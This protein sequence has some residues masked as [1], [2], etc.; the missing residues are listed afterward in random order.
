MI[1]TFEMWFA[2]CACGSEVR[3]AS[4]GKLMDLLESNGWEVQH[5]SEVRCS[6]CIYAAKHY[7]TDA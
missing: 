3:S 4:R 7:R 1:G 2:R 6:S 5:N